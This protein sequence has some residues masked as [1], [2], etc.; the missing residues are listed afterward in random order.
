MKRYLILSIIPILIAIFTLSCSLDLQMPGPASFSSEQG[1]YV[2]PADVEADILRARTVDFEYKTLLP[3][4]VKIETE[5]YDPFAADSSAAAAK[6]L[7]NEAATVFITLYDETGNKV[8][9]GIVGNDG[10]LSTRL[11]LPAAPEDITLRLNADGFESREILIEDMVKY[12]KIRRTLALRASNRST[13]ALNM[14]RQ[15]KEDRDRD[16]VPN[17]EDVDPNNPYEAYEIRIPSE[18]QLSV[19]FEDLFGRADA[20]DADYNDFIA[21]YTITEV[22]DSS[23]EYLSRIKFSVTAREKLAGYNHTFGIR[24]DDFTGKARVFGE[25]LDERGS[26]RKFKPIYTTGPLEIEIFEN[27]RYAKGKSVDFTV[28][29]KEPQNINEE[30]AADVIVD[31]PPY[32][33]YLFVKN[34]GKDIHLVGEETLTDS[35]NPGATYMD[36]DSFPWGLLVP[37]DWKYPEEGQR[38]EVPYPRFTLWRESEGNEHQDWYEHYYDPYEPPTGNN[39]PYPVTVPFSSRYYAEDT[40]LQTFQLQIDEQDGLKDPD[41]DVV[42]FRSSSLP[43]WIS[44]DEDTGLVTVDT[45]DSHSAEDFLFWSEDENG[46]DTR[47]SAVAITISVSFS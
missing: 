29:F 22:V 44:L 27:T 30:G 41:G 45:T 3:V 43:S 46:A 24:L 2:V 21:N 13:I 17:D 18:G 33:P 11:F 1:S 14:A 32:N 40:G 7:D 8:Y 4:D 31:R 36:A 23:G 25:Y 35:N 15:L 47:S 37:A 42:Y 38:I 20:G 12:E 6:S 39:P 34:T 28:E 9:E 16:G 19:A 10:V 26:L 5:L